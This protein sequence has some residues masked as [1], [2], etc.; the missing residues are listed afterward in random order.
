MSANP[1]AIKIRSHKLGVLIRDARLYS[2]KSIADCAAWLGISVS[3]FEA[4]ELGETSPSLPELEMLTDFLGIPFKHFWGNETI[5]REDMKDGALNASKWISLRQRIIGT[6]IK[7]TCGEQGISLEDLAQIIGTEPQQ[8][9][10]YEI[11]GEPIP[12]PTLEAISQTL[13]KPVEIFCDQ[14]G[15]AGTKLF[16]Q[17]ITKA[18]LDL[19]PEMQGFISEPVNRPYLELA[20]RLSEMSVDKLRGVAEGL[21][22]ITL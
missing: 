3:R 10:A 19:P 21:L 13:G 1:L 12:L 2:N 11:N 7:Q 18:F 15:P 14:H 22:E 4:Y 16:R 20:I 5:P 8:L 6:R 17:Q 9:E